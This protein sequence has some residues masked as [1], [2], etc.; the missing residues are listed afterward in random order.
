[1]STST[2][3]PSAWTQIWENAQPRLYS[4]QQSLGEQAPPSKVIRV[5]QLD[6]ELLD[7]ELVQLLQEPLTKALALVNVRGIFSAP[8][9]RALATFS[10][11]SLQR[12]LSRRVDTADPI[13]SV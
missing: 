1:M 5:G 12:P 4:I 6:A 3:T 9:P 8:F 10:P 13:H 7:Q 11:V 2:A